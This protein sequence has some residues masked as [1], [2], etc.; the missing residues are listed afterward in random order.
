[1]LITSGDYS[2][3][4]HHWNAYLMHLSFWGFFLQNFLT[5]SGDLAREYQLLGYQKITWHSSCKIL[6]CHSLCSRATRGVVVQN[7]HS[8]VLL[9]TGKMV[10]RSFERLV[11]KWNYYWQS[12]FICKG[13]LSRSHM[14][15][16]LWEESIY[17]DFSPILK[18]CVIC[19]VYT[20]IYA[21]VILNFLLI[22][23]IQSILKNIDVYSNVFFY[24]F[25]SVYL[26]HMKWSFVW[27]FWSWDC[28]YIWLYNLLI[29]DC[30]ET[31]LEPLPSLSG[32]PV[33]CHFFSSCSGIHCCVDVPAISSTFS[34]KLEIDP[35]TF[36]MVVSIDQLSFSKNLFE[37]EWGQEEEVWLFGVV[38]M[39]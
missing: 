25:F 39:T 31:L 11:V 27:C 37:Y 32:K 23:K 18:K 35:C 34:T 36:Q 7:I 30:N 19:I 38:R 2:H 8:L 1:M 9:T 5:I 21:H 33:T 29:T 20:H 28:F 16:L 10:S 4:Q 3:T 14:Y 6:V 22:F 24:F 26:R 13:I 15:D 17:C 12:T